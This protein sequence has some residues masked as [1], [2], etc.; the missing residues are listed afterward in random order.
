MSILDNFQSVDY[1]IC[2]W[3]I[4]LLILVIKMEKRVPSSQ[5]LGMSSRSTSFVIFFSSDAHQNLQ[6]VESSQILGNYAD[7]CLL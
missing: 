5:E 6:M 3:K 1:S 2:I 4:Q 7:F